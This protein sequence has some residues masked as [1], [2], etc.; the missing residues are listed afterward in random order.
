MGRIRDQ[1]F[2]LKNKQRKKYEG[3][4]AGLEIWNFSSFCFHFQREKRNKITKL[5]KEQKKRLLTYEKRSKDL[6]F[7]PRRLGE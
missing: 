2:Y 7:I 5:D 6:K 4:L 1:I 3:M